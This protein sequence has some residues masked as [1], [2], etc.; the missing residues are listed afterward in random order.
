[1]WHEHSQNS[2]ALTESGTLGFAILDL[3][4]GD[5]REL[6]FVLQRQMVVGLKDCEKNRCQ[7]IYPIQAKYCTLGEDWGRMRRGWIRSG[8][9]SS[10]GS[11][12]VV[13]KRYNFKPRLRYT[14]DFRKIY[15]LWCVMIP[16]SGTMA[17]FTYVPSCGRG[18]GSS[19][20][21]HCRG[22]CPE[23]LD[24]M[25]PS[26][27]SAPHLSDRCLSPKQWVITALHLS[28]RTHLASSTAFLILLLVMAWHSQSAY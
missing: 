25:G 9:G 4:Q 16:A 3:Q 11:T 2:L 12:C 5:M 24:I 15:G 1:M 14:I 8:T 27:H 22:L 28:A 17:W 23:P 6:L 21:C 18:S 20:Y 7:H 10:Y 13:R 26:H 19:V